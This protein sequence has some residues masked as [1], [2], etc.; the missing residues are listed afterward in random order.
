MD[1]TSTDKTDMGT[2]KGRRSSGY[3]KLGVALVA[4]L[5]ARGVTFTAS[6]DRLRVR[7]PAAAL[8]ADVRQQVTS[9]KAEILDALAMERQARPAHAGMSGAVQATF[10]EGVRVQVR[11]DGAAR[12]AMWLM[13]GRRWRRQKDLFSPYAEHMRKCVE[14]RYGAPTEPW[15][16]AEE[17]K[18]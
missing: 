3:V 8:S 9:H 5:R 1:L 15:R 6:N 17:V 2:D 18:Q 4:E 16:P 10:A 12:W 14:E 11:R 7:G 13:N